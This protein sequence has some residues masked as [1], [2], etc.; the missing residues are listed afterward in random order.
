M[1][2]GLK[3]FTLTAILF[4]S[5]LLGIFVGEYNL[6]PFYALLTPAFHT[7]G[8]FLDRPLGRELFIDS[9][10]WN[11]SRTSEKGVIHSAPNRVSNGYTLFTSGH[12]QSAYLMDAK[13]HSLHEWSLP[14]HKAWPNAPHIDQ[15][16]DAALIHWRSLHLYP[17]GD[18]LISYNAVGDP[19]GYGLVRMDRNSKP[20]WK[21]A[22]RSGGSFCV[23]PDGRIFAVVK[24]IRNTPI[25]ELPQ[26]TPPFIDEELVVISPDGKVQKRINLMP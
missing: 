26:I 9:G 7:T 24:K 5:F 13:G 15:P 17:N 23:A 4:L 22:E 3:F 10:I 25:K 19:R 21:L 8:L 16:A 11:P 1:E 18:L 20:V 2:K 6:Q 12:A 14:F